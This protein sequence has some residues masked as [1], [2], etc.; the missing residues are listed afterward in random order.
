MQIVSEVDT[1][2][3]RQIGESVAEYL[4]KRWEKKR[5]KNERED[6]S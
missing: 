5:G 1:L 4:I 6:K 2:A 3:S